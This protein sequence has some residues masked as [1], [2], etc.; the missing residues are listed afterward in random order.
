M[1]EGKEDKEAHMEHLSEELEFRFLGKVNKAAGEPVAKASKEEAG[2]LEVKEDFLQTQLVSKVEVGEL[3]DSKEPKV[4][5][6]LKVEVQPTLKAMAQVKED[7]QHTEH[8]AKV[9]H[10]EPVTLM[11]KEILALMLAGKVAMELQA[12]AHTVLVKEDLTELQALMVLQER[13]ALA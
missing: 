11:A 1:S 7:L 12:K 10:T 6:E 3:A 4:H 8:L 2:E 9:D 13:V 5:G